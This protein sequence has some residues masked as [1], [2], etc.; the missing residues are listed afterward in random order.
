MSTDKDPQA[1][2]SLVEV[3]VSLTVIS[4]GIIGTLS[5]VGANRALMESTWD[6]ARMRMIA[7]SVMTEL[8]VRAQRGET[9]PA[10]GSYN[11]TS[12]PQ[13]LTVLFTDNGYTAAASSLTVA[14]GTGG[15]LIDV[16]LRVTSPGGRSM[17]RERS[18]FDELKTP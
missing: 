10:V 14:S 11:W 4:L 1:G 15:A 12:D 9:L 6:L 13:S 5:M 18:F 3:M 8:A 7:D 2:F 16:T 17:T